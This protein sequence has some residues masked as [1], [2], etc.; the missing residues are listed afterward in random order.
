MTDT[1]T[2]PTEPSDTLPITSTAT[3]YPFMSQSV[4]DG[5]EQNGSATDQLTPV[6]GRQPMSYPPAMLF[7]GTYRQASG[8]Q[9]GVTDMTP[10][11]QIRNLVYDDPYLYGPT[12]GSMEADAM[13]LMGVSQRVEPGEP[14]PEN[15]W[16]GEECPELP[17]GKHG[18]YIVSAKRRR[19]RIL[20]TVHDSRVGTAYLL[21]RG[22]PESDTHKVLQNAVPNRYR[23][24]VT[25]LHKLFIC[26]CENKRFYVQACEDNA[27]VFNGDTTTSVWVS[28]LKFYSPG[29]K[30]PR[31]SGPLYFGIALRPIQEACPGLEY[32]PRKVGR[33]STTRR[34]DV[35]ED[36]QEYDTLQNDIT[37]FDGQ[38][39]GKQNLASIAA[40]QQMLQQQMI[41]MH[42]QAYNMQAAQQYRQQALQAQTVK[43]EEEKGEKET[44]TEE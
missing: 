35:D 30:N 32:T 5:I 37:Q 9:D 40:S 20:L 18:G 27:K 31:L 22:D 39:S 14:G 1:T 16:E 33:K 7:Q 25:N 24:A 29:R 36:D 19:F 23:V 3:Y 26:E 41:Q 8:F 6:I 10:N 38:S 11:L 44:K 12:I 28:V 21:N 13:Y 42:W 43:Q 4:S 15:T 17:P 34:R 2:A